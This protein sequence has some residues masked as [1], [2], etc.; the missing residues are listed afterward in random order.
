MKFYKNLDLKKI[1][2][3]KLDN[4]LYLIRFYLKD[5]KIKNFDAQ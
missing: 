5:E 4:Y 2:V 1:F 3:F